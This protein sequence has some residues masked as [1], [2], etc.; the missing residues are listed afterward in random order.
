MRKNREVERDFGQVHTVGNV[1]NVTP[2]CHQSEWG[3]HQRGS[4]R[5]LWDQKVIQVGRYNKAHRRRHLSSYKVAERVIHIADIN[6]DAVLGDCAHSM[7][8][9]EHAHV[10]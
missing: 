6:A 4:K 9:W 5:N 10:T 3:A 7:K 2:A 8:I 1:A